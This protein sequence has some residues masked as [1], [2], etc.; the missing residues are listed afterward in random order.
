MNRIASLP[1][2][3]LSFGIAA[4]CVVLAVITGI[5]SVGFWV[6]LTAAALAAIYGAR[7]LRAEQTRSG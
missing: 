1:H 7:E 2:H 5:G 3:V 6:L 4:C